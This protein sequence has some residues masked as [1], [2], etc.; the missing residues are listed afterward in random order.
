MGGAARAVPATVMGRFIV[1]RQPIFDSALRVHGYELLFRDPA[2]PRPG[3]DAM[4]A[5]VLVRS[6]LDIGLGSLVGAKPAF[7]NATRTFLVGDQEVPFGSGEVVIEVLED[8]PRDD[9]VVLGCRRLVEKGYQ[10][11]LDDY[12]WQGDG[13]PLLGL[14]SIVKLDALALSSLQLAEGVRHCRQHGV[15]LVAEKVETREQLE[16]CTDLGFHLFQGYLLA[17]PETVEGQSLTPSRVTCLRVL[18]RLCDERTSAKQIEEIVQSDA[19]LSYRFLRAAGAGAASGLYRRL[20]SVQDA[21]VMLGERLLRSWV[22]LMLLAGAHE[23]SDEQL[24]ITLVRA[25]MAERMA[26]ELDPARAGPAFTVGL[27]SAL[28]LLLQAPLEGVVAELSLAPELEDAL[29]ERKGL[30]GGILSDVLAWEVGAEGFQAVSG[31]GPEQVEACY[32]G[33]LTWAGEI[34]R[35]VAAV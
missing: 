29:L 14:A 11:A 12:V 21:V 25:A 1:G 23:G 4:T 8:V 24:A 30:L 3:G 16:V 7:I 5:D 13:D 35:A 28:D 33:A 18:D 15:R 9:E 20:R 6:G 10:L 31:L 2:F 19:A 17:R 27:V 26:H 32:L 22:M 34:C